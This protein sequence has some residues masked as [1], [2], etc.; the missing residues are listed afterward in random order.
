M[1]MKPLTTSIYT[2][3]DLIE[4][5]YL[6]V[7]KKAGLHELVRGFKGQYFLARPRRFGKSLLISTLKAIFQGR[8]ELFDGLFIATTDYDWKPYPVIHLDMGSAA[9]QTPEELEK[10]LCYGIDRNAQQ[11]GITL[12][13]ERAANRFLELVNA[14][15]ARD[16]RVVILVDEY[17]K[18]CSGISASPRRSPSRRCSSNSTASSR[19]P[20]PASGF[21]LLT[22]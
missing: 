4:G 14:L 2:F 16:G 9:A 11:A 17:D 1:S 8:R 3:C 6:Y 12:S 13:S 20:R 10:N 21:A 15:A 7:D 22:G 19:P 18:P 5:G